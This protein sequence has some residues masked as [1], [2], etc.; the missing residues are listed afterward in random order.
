MR[1]QREYMRIFENKTQR[2]PVQQMLIN[3]HQHI[4]QRVPKHL[5]F[6]SSGQQKIL[7]NMITYFV[8]CASRNIICP[9]TSGKIQFN[10]FLCKYRSHIFHNSMFDKKIIDSLQITK[11]NDIECYVRSGLYKSVYTWISINLKKF[12]QLC[13]KKVKAGTYIPESS[14]FTLF[15]MSLV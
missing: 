8:L 1:I 15:C 4:S 7:S 2:Q 9:T 10:L 3:C 11:E 12:N 6:I 14:C 13:Q 5:H